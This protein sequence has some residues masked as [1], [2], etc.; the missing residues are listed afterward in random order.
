MVLVLIQLFKIEYKEELF[1][2]LSSAGIHRTTYCDATNLEKELAG[3]MTLFS[4]IFKSSTEQAHYSK[5]YFCV[6]DE[7]SQVDA[8]I[9]GFEIAGIDWRK[10][11]IFQISV[12]PIS[13]SY[14][15]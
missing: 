15:P 11:E 10:E 2:A 9:E 3:T 4:G 7:E 6:A 13:K 8:I 12:I 14:T 5:L 1:M